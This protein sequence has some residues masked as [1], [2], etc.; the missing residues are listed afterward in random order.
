[1][2]QTATT[3][4]TLCEQIDEIFG[5]IG[6]SAVFWMVLLSVTSKHGTDGTEGKKMR[7]IDADEVMQDAEHFSAFTGNLAGLSDLAILLSGNHIDAVPVV[8]CKGCF[9]CTPILKK[10]GEVYFYRCDYYDI[11]IEENDFCSRGERKD[12]EG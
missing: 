6:M 10:N 3:E 4:E 11:E 7:L 12:G 8:R 9:S 2:G 5:S 1:V